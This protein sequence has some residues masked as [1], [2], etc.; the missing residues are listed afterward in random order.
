MLESL[1]GLLRS[2]LN[3][4][5]AEVDRNLRRAGMAVGLLV[6]AVILFLTA[7]NVLAAALVSGLAELGLDA[8]WASLIVGV[9]FALVGW[10]HMHKGLGDLKLPS[11]APSRT[12]ENVKR[13][14][15]AVKGA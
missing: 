6:A 8:A 3:L 4:A 15:Q 7:L 2:E 13:D 1:S 10:A 11:L 9:V 5:R 14:A 12:T